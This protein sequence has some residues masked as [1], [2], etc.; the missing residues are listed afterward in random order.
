[1]CITFS[2]WFT[3]A[4]LLLDIAG[5]ILLFKYGLPSKMPGGD[6]KIT[7]DG[8]TKEEIRYKRGAYAGLGLLIAGFSLQIVG[9]V[10]R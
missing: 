1:M 6:F 8:T 10:V 9:A 4:G 7:G 5:V 2:Q 3:T